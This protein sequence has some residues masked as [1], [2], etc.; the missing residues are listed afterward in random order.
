MILSDDP[1][2][3]AHYAMARFQGRFRGHNRDEIY[4]EAWLR[5]LEGKAEGLD[6]DEF[7]KRVID[8]VTRYINRQLLWR[9]GR[10]GYRRVILFGTLRAR[11]KQGW[12]PDTINRWRFWR[13]KDS[14]VAAAKRYC[15][16][17]KENRRKGLCGCGRVPDV[18][19]KT[20]S[21]CRDKGRRASSKHRHKR[22]KKRDNELAR[23]RRQ[24]SID[25][26]LC[27]YA[28]CGE[29]RAD[30]D[31]RMCVRHREAER[32]KEARYRARKRARVG[33]QQEQNAGV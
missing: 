16:R 19:Y 15:E 26:G 9:Y 25:A 10:G 23:K 29:P 13:D 8:S 3:L 24:A 33:T 28:G 1:V 31:N 14:A 12:E 17:Q 22:D 30:G 21:R 5:W 2:Q 20:C 18:G 32:A 7:C 6:G 4:Q 27:V 11:S